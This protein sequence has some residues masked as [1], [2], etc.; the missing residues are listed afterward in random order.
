[1]VSPIATRYGVAYCTTCDLTLEYC[2]C[3]ATQAARALAQPRAVEL[4]MRVPGCRICG[5]SIA[6]CRCGTMPAQ[7]GA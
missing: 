6:A 3:A 2:R 5:K 4:T 1:M 7:D